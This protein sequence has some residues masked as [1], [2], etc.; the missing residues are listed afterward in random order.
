MKRCVFLCILLLLAS[1]LPV[2]G[3]AAEEKPHA[4]PGLRYVPVLEDPAAPSAQTNAVRA[5]T[6]DLEKLLSACD[7]IRQALLRGAGSADLSSLG[8]NQS[9]E[10]FRNL[11]YFCPYFDG[12]NIYSSGVY[13]SP[14]SGM[15]TEIRLTNKRST[16]DT[17]AWIS[18]VDSALAALSAQMDTAATLPDQALVLHDYMAS[19]YHYATDYDTNN[20]AFYPGA[21][22][23]K[24]SGVCQAYAYLYQ[25]L[26]CKRGVECY[27]VSSSSMGHAWNLI[28]IN[29][30]YYHID[31]TWDDPVNDYFGQARHNYFL[32][33]DKRISDENHRHTGWNMSSL[34]ANDTTYDSAYWV[35]VDTPI[36]ISGDYRYFCA[37]SALVRY[38]ARTGSTEKLYQLGYWK[39]PGTS[40]FY[41]DIFTGLSVYEDR[42]VFNSY[43]SILTYDLYTGAVE[44][45]F[46]ENTAGGSIF[47]SLCTGNTVTYAYQRTASVSYPDKELRIVTLSHTHRMEKTVVQ[48][49]CAQGGYTLQTCQTCGHQEKQNPTDPLGHS[50]QGSITVANNGKTAQARFVCTRDSGHTVSVPASVTA[51]VLQEPTC[52]AMGVT[53][54]SAA[55]TL[56]GVTVTAQK[57]V[58]D[59]PTLGHSYTDLVTEPTCTQG[60]YTT[61]TCAECG[62]SR[63]DFAVPAR[64]HEWDDGTVI[65]EPTATQSGIR[66]SACT[67]CGE[68]RQ[69]IIPATGET[70]QN[71]SGGSA[72]LGSVFTDMPAPSNWA[73][74]GIDYCLASGLMN[75]STVT[76]FAPKGTMTRGMLAVVLYRMAGSPAVTGKNPYRD[77]KSGRYYADAVIWANE[78]GIVTGKSADRFAPNDDVTRQELVV[79]ISRYCARVDW[80]RV[81]AQGDLSGFADAATVSGYAADSMAWAVENGILNGKEGRLAPKETA[82]RAEVAAIVMRYAAAREQLAQ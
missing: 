56:D 38:H 57:D 82:T 24:G 58:Q 77:V 39:L 13:Y 68:T 54:Y 65:R 64:G 43:S 80:K 53:R 20:E 4:E 47:G 52:A 3:F 78:N 61:R 19:H 29:G 15:I 44:T 31:V 30:K 32:L 79:M 70:E 55:A 12:V 34:V 33:S 27:T 37:N 59:I 40:A 36:Y 18:K 21:I 49:T 75:G 66:V 5:N 50:W 51:R 26:F 48:P 69:Q 10:Q 76:T 62:Y 35:D 17:A 14:S 11:G 73:H 22:L 41:T 60:G 74:A 16:A 45:V 2:F 1:L 9:S 6:S 72:C 25:Y 63:Q 81:Q 8:A 67:H 42:L 7:L 46:T 23:T 28:R 71:C